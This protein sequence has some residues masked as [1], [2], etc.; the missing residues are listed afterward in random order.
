MKAKSKNV[1]YALLRITI[2]INLLAHGMVRI[3]KISS[4]KEWMVD[5]YKDSLLPS[6]ITGTFATTL[7]FVEFAIGALLILGLFTYRTSIA[8]AILIMLLIFGAAMVEQWE[9]VGFQ[10][11][12]ALFFFYLIGNYEHNTITIKNLIK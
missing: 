8:G 11:I 3:P 1:A 12:Y 6:A 7:P 9:W 10:M 2:G 4:F 5:F